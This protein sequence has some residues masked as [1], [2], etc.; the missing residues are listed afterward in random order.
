MKTRAKN[1]VTNI[2]PKEK[3]AVRNGDNR[4]GDAAGRLRKARA[5]A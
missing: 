2:R 4:E 5:D 1:T 3:S